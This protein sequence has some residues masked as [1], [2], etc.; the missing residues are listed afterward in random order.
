[1]KDYEGRLCA[2]FISVLL[3]S[4]VIS[5]VIFT[6]PTIKLLIT[7]F[8]KALCHIYSIKLLK[9]INDCSW[10]SCNESCTTTL[11][12]CKQI[13]VEYRLLINNKTGCIPFYINTVSCG[14]ESSDL[15]DEFYRQYFKID[16]YYFG[17]LVSY[18]D[19]S[20]AVPYNINHT[21]ENVLKDLGLSLIPLLISF[22]SILYIK[23]RKLFKTKIIKKIKNNN[24]NNKQL[25][26][27]EKKIVEIES[28]KIRR[29]LKSNVN[30]NI[31]NVFKEKPVKNCW[32]EDVK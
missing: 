13:K 21:K 8:E 11:Y 26:F 27:Y 4:T 9:N 17:C 7:N 23:K 20:Y 3:L 19:Y 29:I 1:M 10:T 2:I 24:S 14:F 22:I 32:V 12:T 5:F 30:T 25:S 15:C 16:N 6:I 18:G 31:H 28:R